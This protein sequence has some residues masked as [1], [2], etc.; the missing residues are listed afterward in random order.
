MSDILRHALTALGYRFVVLI[1][2]NGR[3]A[4]R[5]I[6]FGGGRPYA[7]VYA[8]L[9]ETDCW[10]NDGGSVDGPSYIDGWE[11]YEPF[12]ARRWPIPSGATE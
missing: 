12:A 3:R 7:R 2:Y 1:Y 6:R 9:P 4:V 11:P 5:R 8:M 10:L